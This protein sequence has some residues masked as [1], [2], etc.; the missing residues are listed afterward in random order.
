M[1]LHT[2]S[3]LLAMS[4]AFLG[5]CGGYGKEVSFKRDVAPILQANCTS[6]HTAPG[7]EGYKKSGLE[8]TSYAGLMK[9]T[10]FG[11]IV[12]PKNSM[13]SALMMLVEGRADPSIRMPHGETPLS[14]TDIA[15]LRKWVEQ[16][17]LN[18]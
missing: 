9:G 1:R 18:N 15:T 10:R 2:Y 14:K 16:G 4:L 11:P 6:C 12:V 17:A 5:G 3:G 8:L 7:G 13:T